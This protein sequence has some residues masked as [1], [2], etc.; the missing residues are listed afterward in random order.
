MSSFVINSSLLT[1][2]SVDLVVAHDGFLC[3]MAVVCIWLFWLQR[4]FL[5]SSSFI[6]LCDRLNIHSW[7][8]SIINTLFSDN[9]Y[10]NLG[11]QCHYFFFDGETMDSPVNIII[12]LKVCKLV[13]KKLTLFCK[14]AFNC[15]KFLYYNIYILFVLIYLQHKPTD[16]EK[17]L[18]ATPF[19]PKSLGHVTAKQLKLLYP[20]CA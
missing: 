8:G 2:K 1:A 20:Y 7:Q 9:Y 18:L 15:T 3:I 13:C 12:Y 16:A 14:A 6:L 19:K 11:K 5:N 17:I 10:N 4:C